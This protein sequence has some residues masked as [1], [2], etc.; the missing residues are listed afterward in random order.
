MGPG[1]SIRAESISR[2]DWQGLY[3][4]LHF[5][6]TEAK[7]VAEADETVAKR[8]AQLEAKALAALGKG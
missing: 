6:A 3:D 4:Y 2:R 1:T 7:S 8:F 5:L